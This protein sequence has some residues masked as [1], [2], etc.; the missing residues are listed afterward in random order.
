M[1]CYIPKW[2][3]QEEQ[4]KIHESNLGSVLEQA[5]LQSKGSK[6]DD[7]V[8]GLCDLGQVS[9]ALTSLLGFLTLYM[10]YEYGGGTA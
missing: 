10:A 3:N 8:Q 1:K 7:L 5:T 6:K 2:Q 9:E 4:K